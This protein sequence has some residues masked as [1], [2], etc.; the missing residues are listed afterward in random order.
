MAPRR[1]AKIRIQL[2]KVERKKLIE[3]REI[4][5]EYNSRKNNIKKEKKVNF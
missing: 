4:T 5:Q 1:Q 3:L 2:D